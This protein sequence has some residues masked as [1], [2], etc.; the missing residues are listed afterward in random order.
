MSKELKEL[1]SYVSYMREEGD[2]DLR[3]ILWAIDKLIEDPN[4]ELMEVE[5]E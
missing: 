5:R 4:Y 3:S 2:T 1:R